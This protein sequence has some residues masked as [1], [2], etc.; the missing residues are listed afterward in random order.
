LHSV[1]AQP[2]S[3]GAGALS[4]HRTPYDLS[5][6]TQ[7][8]QGVLGFR[9][10][11]DLVH[12]A[13]DDLLLCAVQHISLHLCKHSFGCYHRCADFYKRKDFEV[14]ATPDAAMGHLPREYRR[15]LDYETVDVGKENDEN[16]AHCNAVVTSFL[17]PIM[18][19]YLHHQPVQRL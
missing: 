2:D 9:F 6:S 18:Y 1:S 17:S 4:R 10:G 19:F 13:H 5:N 8:S 14:F 12:S 11:V 15:E 7:P 16:T 3:P